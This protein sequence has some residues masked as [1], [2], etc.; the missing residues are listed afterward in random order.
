[1]KTFRLEEHLCV[2]YTENATPETEFG[3]WAS[4]QNDPVGVIVA[5][6]FEDRSLGVLQN[7]AASKVNVQRLI[8]GEYVKNSELNA[9][10]KKE[11]EKLAT[12]IAPRR[13]EV[14]PNNDDGRWVS[15]AASRIDASHLMLDISGISNSAMFGALDSVSK[16][17]RCVTIGYTDAEEY[18]PRKSDWEKL[19]T[20]VAG[21]EALSRE[22]DRMPWLQGYQH[23]VKLVEG[24]EGYDS[25]GN[26]RALVAFLPF[27]SARL[28]SVLSAE[29]FS[30]FLFLAVKPRFPENIWRL[31]A[32][33]RINA[34]IIKNWPVVDI[35]AFGYR[36]AIR[37][38]AGLLCCEGSLLENYDLNFA[39]MGSKLQ[40]L[41]CWVVCNFIPCIAVVSST[42]AK[43]YPKAFSSGIGT[44][45]AIPLK[46]PNRNL[47]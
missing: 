7:L 29:D 22:A 18:W 21:G 14:I 39:V 30:A 4:E 25:V 5:E 2:A 15:T 28:A 41:A 42:P 44:S 6:G 33:K 23:S 47:R 32:L 10:Y 19:Q 13:W 12:R 8:I 38:I 37:A 1:M 9:A 11:F 45:W 40:T 17:G 34:P 27:K 26:S 46:I 20:R 16:A 3:Q 36:E 43:Y 31:E 24:H 35:S